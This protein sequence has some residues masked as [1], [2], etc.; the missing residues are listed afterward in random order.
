MKLQGRERESFI[1]R[2]DELIHGLWQAEDQLQRVE[3]ISLV[4]YTRLKNLT[5]QPFDRTILHRTFPGI[6]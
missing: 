4:F 6:L 5:K 2:T 1:P 3:L